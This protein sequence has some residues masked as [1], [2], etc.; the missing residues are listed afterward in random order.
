MDPDFPRLEPLKKH[1]EELIKHAYN[2]RARVL[3]CC[4]ELQLPHLWVAQRKTAGSGVQVTKT[5]Q[6]KSLYQNGR[7]LKCLT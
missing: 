4:T 7:S 1:F 2:P 3:P 6:G 5:N